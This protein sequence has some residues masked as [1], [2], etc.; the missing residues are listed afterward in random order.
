MEVC[1][2]G[3]LSNLIISGRPNEIEKAEA[4]EAIVKENNEKNGSNAY[5]SYFEGIQ[6][7]YTLSNEYTMVR[8]MLIKIAMVVDWDTIKILNAKGYRINTKSSAKYAESIERA[9]KKSSNLMTRAKMKFN[10]INLLSAGT[11]GKGESFE[12]VMANLTAMLKFVV[13]D[14]ITLSRYNEYR[15]VIKNRSKRGNEAE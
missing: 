14:D 10:E 2:S 15:K 9:F 5:T 11:D 4:W 8:A 7:Y 12:E 3:D 1:T 6:N 13:P